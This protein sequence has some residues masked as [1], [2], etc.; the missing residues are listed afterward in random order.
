MSVALSGPGT[1]DDDAVPSRRALEVEHAEVL[2]GEAG[3]TDAALDH[4][5]VAHGGGGVRRAGARTLARR[6]DFAPNAASDVEAMHVG[7]GAGETWEDGRRD[8]VGRVRWE[9]ETGRDPKAGARR[10]GM[11]VRGGDAR[12]PLVL[13]FGPSPSSAVAPPKTIRRCPSPSA[14]TQVSVCPHLGPGSSL[15][16]SLWNSAQRN[17]VPAAIVLFINDPQSFAR[18]AP[19]PRRVDARRGSDPRVAERDAPDLCAGA[20]ATRLV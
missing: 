14:G 3:G 9:T 12:M 18:P 11:E 16:G 19:P 20:R 2:G 13:P 6:V 8:G 5:H 10:G 1:A 15:R 7:G 17:P 4:D